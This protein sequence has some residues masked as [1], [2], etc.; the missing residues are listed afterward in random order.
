[1]SDSLNYLRTKNY[2]IGNIGIHLA[3]IGRPDFPSCQ[4]NMI[5]GTKKILVEECPLNNNQ[6]DI[7][8]KGRVR[9]MERGTRQF[10]TGLPFLRA[11]NGRLRPEFQSR[12]YGYIRHK[13][14]LIY[15]KTL[16]Y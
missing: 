12:V 8:K 7:V 6:E 16:M 15:H 3:R 14:K 4:C 5:M 9:Q 1:M 11:D 13:I 10:I 2:L